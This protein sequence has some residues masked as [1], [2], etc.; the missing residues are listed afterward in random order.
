MRAMM[1][2]AISIGVKITSN[3]NVDI[4]A[5]DLRALSLTCVISMVKIISHPPSLRYGRKGKD[6]KAQSKNKLYLRVC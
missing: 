5:Q 2:K 1:S 3:E 6:A 4:K